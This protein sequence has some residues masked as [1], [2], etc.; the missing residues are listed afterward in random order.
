MALVGTA[1]CNSIATS[2]TLAAGNGNR[3]VV[4]GF[5]LKNSPLDATPTG[6]TYGGQ[7]MTHAV[8]DIL[9]GTDPV[10]TYFFYLLEADLPANGAHTVDVSAL[11][12]NT[13]SKGVYIACFDDLT[14][15]APT[16]TGSAAPSS[17]NSSID[18]TIDTTNDTAVYFAGHR[19]T[20]TF[21]S[22]TLDAYLLYDIGSGG[23][24]VVGGYALTEPAGTYSASWVSTT[25]AAGRVLG[26]SFAQLAAAA[27]TS[28]ILQQHG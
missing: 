28:T 11:N 4:V 2:H 20:E 19:E 21:S 17:T 26:M 16:F 23:N 27:G 12:P 7:T 6:V 3:V 1:I 5:F 8:S 22:T 15:Q 13:G 18:I 10:S 9:T 25:S 14:Q 24:G